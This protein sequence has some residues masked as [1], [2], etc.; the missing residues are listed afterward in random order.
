MLSLELLPG[1]L[2]LKL[3]V[4]HRAQTETKIRPFLCVIICGSV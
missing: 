2:P 4:L 1:E 3:H